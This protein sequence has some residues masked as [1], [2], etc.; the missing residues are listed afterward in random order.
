MGTICNLL[1]R[2]FWERTELVAEE[3]TA[4]LQ[5]TAMLIGYGKYLS[6]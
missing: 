1:E 5:L 2:D 4:V 6:V 3:D